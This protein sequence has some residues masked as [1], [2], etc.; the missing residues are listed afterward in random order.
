MGAAEAAPAKESTP[1]K[2]VSTPAKVSM[3]VSTPAKTT[4]SAAPSA[5]T[6]KKARGPV[7]TAATQEPSKETKMD[8]E[9]LKEAQGLGYERALLN[10]ASRQEV[11]NRKPSE[12]LAALKKSEGLVNPAKN[13]LLGA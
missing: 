12:L 6:A 8:P 11:A 13:A 5:T 3:E 4:S 1:A 7:K 2:G 9:V 10:L